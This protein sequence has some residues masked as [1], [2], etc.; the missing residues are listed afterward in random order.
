MTSY[1]ICYELVNNTSEES[2]IV[3]LKSFGVWGRVIGNTWL[4]QSDKNFVTIRDEIAECM[5]DN[6]RLL[7]VQTA[8]HAAWKDVLCSNEWL[9]AHV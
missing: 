9:G 1:L 7:V 3:K 8:N 6:D 5:G 4:I 2:I